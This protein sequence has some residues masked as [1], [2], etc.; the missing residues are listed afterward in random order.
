MTC[1]FA[2]VACGN[3]EKENKYVN[4]SSVVTEF[5]WSEYKTKMASPTDIGGNCTL[6]LSAKGDASNVLGLDLNTYDYFIKFDNTNQRYQVLAVLSTSNG[7]DYSIQSATTY[8]V[9]ENKAYV[10][11]E[12]IGE[13]G[14]SDS[15]NPDDAFASFACMISPLIGD[16]ANYTLTDFE[17]S[18]N[19]ATNTTTITWQNLT[20][21]AGTVKIWW[22]DQA[23]GFEGFS[24]QCVA[25]IDIDLGLAAGG[26]A[27]T[28][29]LT[30]RP[31]DYYST[32]VD[33]NAKNGDTFSKLFNT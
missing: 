21:P 5:E 27:D 33:V 22:T 31:G 16:M 8:D 24:S 32:V 12:V 1:A 13:L 4:E 3:G 18:R 10:N 6:R 2:L 11:G 25:W 29:V 28:D 14:M 9:K 23:S 30:I 17:T 7:G 19:S 20:L 26:E 15:D